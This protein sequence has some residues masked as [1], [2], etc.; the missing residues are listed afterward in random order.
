MP[1]PWRRSGE[2]RR[3]ARVRGRRG[4]SL[5]LPPFLSIVPRAPPLPWFVVRAAPLLSGAVEPEVTR[6]EM[7]ALGSALASTLLAASAAA[8]LLGR[9]RYV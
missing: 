9:I 1:A 6:R 5:A 4:V 2:T 8:L 3:E 7:Q